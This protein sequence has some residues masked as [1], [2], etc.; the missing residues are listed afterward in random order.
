VT[1]D[2]RLEQMMEKLRERFR[3]KSN[4]ND[5]GKIQDAT[6]KLEIAIAVADNR[7]VPVLK[8]MPM[9]AMPQVVTHRITGQESPHKLG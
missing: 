1:D 2:Y 3:R 6:P 4:T 8:D 9:P 7:F 5:N